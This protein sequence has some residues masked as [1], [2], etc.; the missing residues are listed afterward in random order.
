MAYFA[1][2][3]R[4]AFD[5][6]QKLDYSIDGYKVPFEKRVFPPKTPQNQRF[7]LRAGQ[8]STYWPQEASLHGSEAL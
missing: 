3:I 1:K 7:G 8:T 2:H 4:P 6:Q 5:R